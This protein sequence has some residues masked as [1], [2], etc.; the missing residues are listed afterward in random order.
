MNTVIFA[1]ENSSNKICAA[2]VISKQTAQSKQ[3]PNKRK[4][5]KSG[6]PDCTKLQFYQES[7]P[8]FKMLSSYIGSKKLSHTLPRLLVDQTIN[9]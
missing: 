5:V 8:D 7:G 2:L 4:L 9:S 3:S 1:V 6:H